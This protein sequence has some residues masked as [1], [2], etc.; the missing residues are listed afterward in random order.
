MDE[1][2]STLN[3]VTKKSYKRYFLPTVEI[4]NYNAAIDGRK[5]FYESLKND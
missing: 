1:E 5:F 4:K 3:K 2:N